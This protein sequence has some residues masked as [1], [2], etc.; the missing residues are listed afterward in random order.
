MTPSRALRSLLFAAVLAVPALSASAQADDRLLALLPAVKAAE[1]AMPALEAKI[2]TGFKFQQAPLVLFDPTSKRALLVH[3]P[4][5]PDGFTPADP[6]VPGSGIGSLPAGVTLFSGAAQ[7]FGGRLAGC[8]DVAQMEGSSADAAR[9]LLVREAFRV[10]EQYA[11]IPAA[12]A[13]PSGGYPAFLPEN[14]ALLRAE[15]R[16]CVQLAHA[17]PA[18]A[19]GLAAALL[20]LRARRQAKLSPDALAFER[21]HEVADGL[22]EY[23]GFA[24][25]DRTAGVRLLDGLL[26]G[27][28]APGKAADTRRF[29]ATGAAQALLFDTALTGWKA[30]FDKTTRDSLEPLLTRVAGSTP[31]ADTS[32]LGLDGLVAE[33]TRLEQERQARQTQLLAAVEKAQGLVLIV[34]LGSALDFPG[35]KW[36]SRYDPKGMVA[37]DQT[38][39]LHSNFKLA[40][41]GVLDFA[42]SRP[43]LYVVRKSVTTGFDPPEVP[44]IVVDG[45]PTSFSKE[46]PSAT[47]K[48]EVRGAMFQFTAEHARADWDP[49]TRRLTVTPLAPGN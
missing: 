48:V 11:G 25:I 32:A 23:A 31:A 4:A 44:Y 46:M 40:G 43:T 27:Y 37:I 12:P 41:T 24:S 49:A 10:Y 3:F 36:S 20:S 14:N 38:R 9:R 22:A 21:G 47:G 30:S 2:W 1:A 6:T 17:S 15:A 26:D 13:P 19:P 39:V 35:V 42:A 28:A 7:P 34:D 33:E 5:L 18:E 45:R 16:L 8:L 29:S